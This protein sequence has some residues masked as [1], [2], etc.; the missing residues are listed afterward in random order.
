MARDP[1]SQHAR[2]LQLIKSAERHLMAAVQDG[3]DHR[4]MRAAR[5]LNGIVD[6]AK[7]VLESER[8]HPPA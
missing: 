7:A 4:A 6:R 5:L 3:D 2:H 8:N 1:E